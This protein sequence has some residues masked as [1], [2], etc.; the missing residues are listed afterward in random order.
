MAAKKNEANPYGLA[1]KALSS[2]KSKIQNE[3][4]YD[5]IKA[6]NTNGN[7]NAKIY[8]FLKGKGLEE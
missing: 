7:Q 5:K 3:I 2:E 1:W 8:I 4:Q 6:K